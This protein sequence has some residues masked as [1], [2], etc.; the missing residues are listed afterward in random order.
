[1]GPPKQ[2]GPKKNPLALALLFA[3]PTLDLLAG[4]YNYF[5]TKNADTSKADW[6]DTYKIE[7]ISGAASLALAVVQAFVYPAVGIALGPV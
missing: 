2:G 7:L 3:A 5:E 6:L 1:M 4:A